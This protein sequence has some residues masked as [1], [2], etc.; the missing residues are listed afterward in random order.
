MTDTFSRWRF[1]PKQ[2]KCIPVAVNRSCQSKNLFH[3]E[4]A[5]SSVCPGKSTRWSIIFNSEIKSNLPFG[6]TVLSQCERLRLR[7]TLAAKRSGQQHLSFQPRCDPDTGLWSPI[8]CLGKAAKPNDANGIN[9]AFSID[10]PE[11]PTNTIGV[12]WCADK[13]GAPV[14]GTLTRGTEP[15]CNHRQAR[16]RTIDADAIQDPVMEELIRQM[17]VIV[18]E[19][20]FI[21]TELSDQS[22]TKDRLSTT[23]EQIL[24]IANSIFEE[25]LQSS[26]SLIPTT[27]RCNALK[28]TASFTVKCDEF[29][30][31]EPTQ[32]SNNNATCWCVDQA[33]NQISETTFAIGSKKCIFTP[34]DVVS[35]DLH[36]TSPNNKVFRNVYDILKVEL[37]HLLGNM[38]DNLRVHENVDGGIHLRFDLMDDN[39]IETAFALEE[40]VKQNNLILVHGEMKPEITLSRFVYKVSNLPVPQKAS[41]IPEST[42]QTIVFILATTSAFLVSIFVVFVMLKRGKNK[43]K[44]YNTNKSIGINDKFLDYSS[45]IFVL[46]ANEEK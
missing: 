46:S 43:M 45:P 41:L 23:T 18:D 32:C 1:S 19:D 22:A 44:T 3:N 38:P 29:G 20:N 4:Q 30:S 34:I 33:G 35:I 40:M 37:K 12:C 11:D 42:F 21:E 25:S 15:M 28:E 14:K 39:K 6:F 17:T 24:E 10:T 9:R 36:L 31:F 5:C 16:R 26:Q 8:Q 13:K 7:N 27:S 2:N